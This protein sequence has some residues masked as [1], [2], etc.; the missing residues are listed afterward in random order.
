MHRTTEHPR[1]WAYARRLTA[2]PAFG[3][4]LDLDGIARRHHAHCRGTEAAG[5]AVP[6]MDWQAY[7]RRLT[8]WTDAGSGAGADA[9]YRL[10]AGA[11]VTAPACF[12][13]ARRSPAPR[14]GH[15]CR[16]RRRP[17]LRAAARRRSGGRDGGAERAPSAAGVTPSGAPS[18][19]RAG[20]VTAAPADGLGADGGLSD[21]RRCRQPYD[22]GRS[23]ARRDQRPHLHRGVLAAP[24][25][26]SPT[27][28]A[29]TTPPRWPATAGPLPTT[30][31]R[32]RTG[33]APHRAHRPGGV[34]REG[35]GRS[36][37]PPGGWRA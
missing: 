37:P 9:A 24:L 2:H 6:I 11:G 10:T 31:G 3:P 17:G 27:P 5:A 12:R 4:H 13:P 16:L 36:P 8:P 32:R 18:T 30:R 15:R 23:G 25:K 7:V 26:R 33:R 20:V 21:D 29:G 1:L 22:T 34:R 19:A 28:S 35:P 14:P